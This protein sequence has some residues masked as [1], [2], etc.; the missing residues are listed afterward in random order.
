MTS[1]F[2]KPTYCLCPLTLV[3]TVQ[4]FIIIPFEIYTN[5]AFTRSVWNYKRADFNK[6]NMLISNFNW[7][8]LDDGS[9]DDATIIFTSKFIELAKQM[10]SM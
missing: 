3:T 10:Y 6:F 5:K 9:V 7:A 4:H 1:V 2:L 8:I